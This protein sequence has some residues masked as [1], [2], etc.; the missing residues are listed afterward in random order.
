MSS[1]TDD[2]DDKINFFIRHLVDPTGIAQERCLSLVIERVRETAVNLAVLGEVTRGTRLLEIL[3]SHGIPPFDLQEYGPEKSSEDYAKCWNTAKG[4]TD[5]DYILNV[6]TDRSDPYT[7][8]VFAFAWEKLGT[9]PAWATPAPAPLP[10]GSAPSPTDTDSTQTSGETTMDALERYSRSCVCNRFGHPWRQ[11]QDT[12]KLV[13]EMGNTGKNRANPHGP[14]PGRLRGFW[15]LWERMLA[16]WC[17]NQV[18][19]ST[20]RVLALDLSIRL[21][22]P[23]ECDLAEDERREGGGN[24]REKEDKKVKGEEEEEEVVEEFFL[25]DDEVEKKEKE[26]NEDLYQ[27]SKEHVASWGRF[28]AHQHQAQ[29]QLPM[30]GSMRRLWQ[31]GWFTDPEYNSFLKELDLDLDHVRKVADAGCEMLVKRLERGPDRV[32]AGATISELVRAIDR[33]TRANAPYY[34]DHN[35]DE[36]IVALAGHKEMDEDKVNRPS[37]LLRLPV[38]THQE[39]TELEERLEVTA[40][41]PDQYKAFLRT[42]NGMGPIWWNETQLIR[43]LCPISNVEVSEDWEVPIQLEL[44]PSRSLEPTI[45][46]PLLRRSI[47]VSNRY[48]NGDVFLVEPKLVAEAKAVFF[49]VYDALPEAGKAKLRREVEEVYGTLEAFRELEWAVLLWTDWFAEM[50][51]YRD[52]AALL[53]DFAVGSQRKMRPWSMYWSPDVRKMSGFF[54]LPQDELGED[55]DGP[56]VQPGKGNLVV[57]ADGTMSMGENV[58]PDNAFTTPQVDH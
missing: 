2:G 7:R 30:L 44:L 40:P 16:P 34:P 37:T 14:I 6:S 8:A 3:D 29:D 55:E 17:M 12:L 58:Y 45:E 1:E 36:R 19:K 15:L 32:Y 27:Q 53:E 24:L 42:T 39:I 9:W 26:E 10:P 41:L 56:T 11:D 47:S 4:G 31:K 57:H 13:S 51:S 48:G 21:C 18:V 28:I 22:F 38:P 54:Y 25:D 52:F 49:E 43:L 23:D 20:G 46:W 5:Q 35:S 33:N 50:L